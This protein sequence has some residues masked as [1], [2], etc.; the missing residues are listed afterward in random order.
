[1]TASE[2]ERLWLGTATDALI[3]R[4]DAVRLMLIAAA[5]AVDIFS[6]VAAAILAAILRYEN[7]LSSSTVD[8]IAVVLPPYLLASTAFEAYRIDVLSGVIN[9]VRRAL[10]ALFISGVFGMAAAFAFKATASYSRIE[11]GTMFLLAMA[12]IILG[13]LII[14]RLARNT[15][16]AAIQPNIIIIGDEGAA[17][18]ARPRS[19]QA[20]VINVR[21]KN[22]RPANQ[23]PAFLDRLDKAVHDADRV[24]LV[25]ADPDERRKWVETM[26]FTGINAEVVEPQ[27]KHI[28]ALGIA[29]W[30]GSATLVVSRGPMKFNER[31]LKRV[32]DLTVTLLMIPL[33]V[34]LIAILA[35]LV[36]L[37]SPGPA[38]FVQK[39]I[40][41][42]NRQ[43]RCF[44][45][46]TMRSDMQDARGDRSASQ[47][48]ERVTM[49]GY[50]L[51]HWSL[52]ELPQ[53]FNVLRGEMSL[54]GP[55]PHP[56]GAKA[57]GEL[58]WEAVPDYWTRHAMKP[59]ITGLA[60]IRG[61]R[62]ATRSKQDIEQ[63]VAADLEYINSWSI[64]LDLKILLLTFRVM[65]HPN[66]Y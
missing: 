47:R 3:R 48:D 10:M 1:M 15:L 56:L 44:K 8:L 9:S 38:F 7:I 64:W 53:L 46:R 39:R 23:D 37:E 6:I 66:A 21:R 34:P 4:R 51:R 59:G 62:G 40:G 20:K 36:K 30:N 22:W 58:F 2:M 13:R 61:Y 27:L 11:T 54:V 14:A 19:L 50:Y 26:R 60:Q 25:F 57:Q 43:Y 55:R 29:E 52:D 32:F 63:R 28:P 33:A 18:Q 49:L 17:A 65:A 45:L 42:N 41:R 35:L 31:V 5:V 12:A 16:R 24:L